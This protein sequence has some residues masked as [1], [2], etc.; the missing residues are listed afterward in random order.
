MGGE[1]ALVTQPHEYQVDFRIIFWGQRVARSFEGRGGKAKGFT[2]SHPSPLTWRMPC[3]PEGSL[4][5]QVKRRPYFCGLGWTRLVTTP[6]L[7]LR[8]KSPRTRGSQ[9]AG[10][11]ALLYGSRAGAKALPLEPRNSRR[12]VLIR[13]LAQQ[14]AARGAPSDALPLAPRGRRDAPQ[15]VRAP[16]RA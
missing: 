7:D 8:D 11:K 3:A 14:R 6:P 10:D 1:V 5:A 9:E 15:C 2:F 4:T 16:R 13:S 12:R